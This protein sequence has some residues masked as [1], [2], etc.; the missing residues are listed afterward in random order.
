[1]AFGRWSDAG[2]RTE[3]RERAA[4][5]CSSG[6][7]GWPRG[8]IHERQSDSTDEDGPGVGKRIGQTKAIGLRRG[9]GGELGDVVE[10]ASD[11]DAADN[12]AVGKKGNATGLHGV[13]VAL[14]E[15]RFSRR[16]AGP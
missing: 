10:N 15:L 3:A 11:A 14:V 13:G 2:D 5:E 9:E 16:D 12:Y 7:A 6:E 1:M 8:L 4:V